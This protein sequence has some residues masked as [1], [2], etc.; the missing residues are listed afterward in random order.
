MTITQK[1]LNHFQEGNQLTV[2]D[3][4]RLFHT[5]ELRKIVSTLKDRGHS[6]K[7]R[8]VVVDTADGRKATVNCYYYEQSKTN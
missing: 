4:L 6:I 8:P 3:A 2:L 5:T 1:I 7:A